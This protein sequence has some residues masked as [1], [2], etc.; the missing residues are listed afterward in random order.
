MENKVEVR[1]DTG[2][3]TTFWPTAA[4]AGS[5]PGAD[6]FCAALAGYSQAN[7]FKDLEG[8]FPQNL[9]EGMVQQF[10]EELSIQASPGNR[11]RTTDGS[12]DIHAASGKTGKSA[13]KTLSKQYTAGSID[14]VGRTA[15]TLASSEV[16]GLNIDSLGARINKPGKYTGYEKTEYGY[17]QSHPAQPGPDY[18]LLI[19]DPKKMTDQ[20]KHFMRNIELAQLIREGKI[21][22]HLDDFMDSEYDKYRLL[23]E[24][25]SK[26]HMNGENGGYNVKLVNDKRLHGYEKG[27]LEVVYSTVTGKLDLSA[28]NMPTINR[29]D[30]DNIWE[31]FKEDMVPYYSYKNTPHD[32]IG[33]LKRRTGPFSIDQSDADKKKVYDLFRENFGKNQM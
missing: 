5:G 29:A 33:W 3:Q 7:P 30:P 8:D 4:A 11:T 12:T 16:N 14:D 9:F 20:Q 18:L 27:E 32:S 28:E 26:Y 25:K 17:V 13:G 10:G 2:L 1:A 6:S 15:V 21:P 19:D 31:H 22:T 24:G 23:A